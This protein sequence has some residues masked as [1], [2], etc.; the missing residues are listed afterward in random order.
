MQDLTASLLIMKVVG[1]LHIE[2]V[3][4]EVQL[5]VGSESAMWGD[6]VVC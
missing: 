6:E 1:V 3:D 5:V 2:E 4:M